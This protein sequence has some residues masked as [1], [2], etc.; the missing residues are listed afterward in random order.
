MDKFAAEDR[1]GFLQK[2][3]VFG[4]GALSVMAIH[5]TEAKAG[6]AGPAQQFKSIQNHENAHVTFLVNALGAA[7]RPKPTF[8]N[9]RQTTRAQFVKISQALEVT[10][11]GAYLGATPA[12]NNPGY[13][14][15]AASIALIEAEHSGYLNGYVASPVTADTNGI[16]QS[17][18]QP[19]TAQQVVAAA[20]GFIQSLNGGPPLS[21]SNVRS[22]ENDIAILNYA[23]A[24]E[25]LEA[26]FYNV[27]VARFF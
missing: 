10:G 1:R 2:G 5:G 16:E 13:L 26:E 24:L 25:Y 23:L 20:G 21:Y 11:V 3:L 17:F 19:L 22:D 18:A 14:A 7:A 8:K 27:N 12:I 9:L 15:A 4:V 6:V